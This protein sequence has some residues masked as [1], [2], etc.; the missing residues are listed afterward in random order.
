MAN[1]RLFAGVF[2]TCILYADRERMVDGDYAPLA[3]LYFRTLE[4][5]F[6]G[7]CPLPLRQEIAEDAAIYQGKRGE[8]FRLSASDQFITLGYGL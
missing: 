8:P 3:R 6:E 1:P 5:V 2:P 4:L 7:D